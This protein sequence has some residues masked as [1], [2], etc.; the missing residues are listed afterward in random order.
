MDAPDLISDDGGI[1]LIPVRSV[2]RE[3]MSRNQAAVLGVL[4]GLSVLLPACFSKPAN[5][6]ADP[7]RRKENRIAIFSSSTRWLRLLV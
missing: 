1:D 6:A 3:M 5:L 7:A 2:R 4:V